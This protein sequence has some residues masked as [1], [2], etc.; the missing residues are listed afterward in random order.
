VPERD[1][2]QIIGQNIRAARIRS[3][4][5]QECLA[6]LLGIHWQTLSNIERGVHPFAVTTFAQIAQYLQ[7][8]SDALLTGLPLPNQKRTQRITKALARRRRPPTE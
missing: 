2:L 1:P 8:S 7:I 6:E 5:T 4:F 3:G